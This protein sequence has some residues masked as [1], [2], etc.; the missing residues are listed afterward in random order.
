MQELLEYTIATAPCEEDSSCPDMEEELL[1]D[2]ATSF[3]HTS[4]CPNTAADE[5][6]PSQAA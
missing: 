1:A 5:S 2:E 4:G 6:A 3:M